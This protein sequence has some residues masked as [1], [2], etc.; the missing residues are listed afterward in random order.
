M[1]PRV[2][3]AFLSRGESVSKQDSGLT[4]IGCFLECHHQVVNFF[5]LPGQPSNDPVAYGPNCRLGVS[6]LSLLSSSSDLTTFGLT[7]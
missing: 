6:P 3:P 7:M 4:G 2:S 1:T 5:N